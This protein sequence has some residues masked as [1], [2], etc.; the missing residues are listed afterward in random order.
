MTAVAAARYLQI[1][2]A[3]ALVDP[4][5]CDEMRKLMVRDVRNQNYQR[6]RIAGGVPK[7]AK[8]FSKTGT[9]SD[10]FHD[11]GIVV[12]PNGHKFILTVFITG[13]TEA[14]LFEMYHGICATYFTNH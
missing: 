3:D 1:L 8:V 2:A 14:L 7:G 4:E 10:T 12:L 13:N 9:T 11:A 5:S 6:M